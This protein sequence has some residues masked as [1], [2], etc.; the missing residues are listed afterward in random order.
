MPTVLHIHSKTHCYLN[1]ENWA[2]M[3]IIQGLKVEF[4]TLQPVC[5]QVFEKQDLD[6][7]SKN[8][9]V[10]GHYPPPIRKDY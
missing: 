2:N 4:F 1:Q 10:L 7:K 5:S 9:C 6:K 3:K 8:T